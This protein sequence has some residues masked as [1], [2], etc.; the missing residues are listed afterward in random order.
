MNITAHNYLNLVGSETQNISNL[1]TG[2][3]YNSWTVGAHCAT[4]YLDSSAMLKNIVEII[5]ESDQL[6]DD[7]L[8]FVS[9]LERIQDKTKT[10]YHEMGHELFVCRFLL[11]KTVAHY[12]SMINAIVQHDALVLGIPTTEL[13]VDELMNVLNEPKNKAML[14]KSIA[15]LKAGNLTHHRLIHE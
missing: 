2:S 14:E 4:I 5:K 7:D 15:E 8:S 6:F 3:I 12:S 1:F 9:Q 11:K 13:P 10:I